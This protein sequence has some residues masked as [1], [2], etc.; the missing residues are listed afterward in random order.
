MGLSSRAAAPPLETRKAG[1]GAPAPT[2]FISYSIIGDNDRPK[3]AQR[4]NSRP[5]LSLR[6]GQDRMV[7]TGELRRHG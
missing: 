1:V 5:V 3:E 7:S 6:F 2:D 4:L